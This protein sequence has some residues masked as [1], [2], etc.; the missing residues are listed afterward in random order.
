MIDGGY[1]TN[2]IPG[3]ATAAVDGRFLPGHEQELLDTIDSLLLPSVR[4]EFI[5]HDV[6]MQ[7]EFS[8]TLWRSP[9]ASADSPAP[10]AEAAKAHAAPPRTVRPSRGAPRPASRGCRDRGPRRRGRARAAGSR[11]PG[12]RPVRWTGS[13]ERGR[14]PSPPGRGWSTSS[15]RASTWNGWGGAW[16]P[17]SAW[18]AAATPSWRSA[19]SRRCRCCPT[20]PTSTRRSR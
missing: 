2:V 15:A 4:R 10:L 14:R 8:G 1:Q 19:K 7:T 9:T 11:L 3:R 20:A 12:R 5:H 13:A 16:S 17:T 18:P 6:A